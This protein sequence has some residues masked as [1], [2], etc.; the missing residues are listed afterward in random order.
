[1]SDNK[2]T[3]KPFINWVGGKRKIAD[4]L[5]SY[6]PEGLNNYY[7]PFLG[8]GALFFAVKNKFKKCFLSDINYELVT[9]YNTV[10]KNPEG[11]AKL[12]S[13]HAENHSREYYYKI[14]NKD[15]TNNPGEITARFIYLNRYSFKGIYRINR[16]GKSGITIST[17]KIN[18]TNVEER[19]KECSNFLKDVPIHT[20]DFSF[21]E[22]QKDDFVYFDPPYH[23]AGERF[24]TRLPFGEK[25]QIRLKDFAMELDSKN[26][27]FMISNSNTDFIRNLYNGYNINLVEIKYL[28]TGQTKTSTE[29]VI[30]NY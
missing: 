30:T 14:R 24:Y 7:E 11:V 29:V 4:K 17:K 15:C 5:I 19:L 21:I 27:K 28:I 25:D 23:K 13:S 10:K 26:V 8:G 22:P 12:Y 1:M 6:I 20:I 16:D 2:N 9:S 3:P 18:N